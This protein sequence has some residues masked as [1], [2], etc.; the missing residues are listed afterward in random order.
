MDIIK[1]V[2]THADLNEFYYPPS[3]YTVVVRQEE[4]PKCGCVFQMDTSWITT[5]EYVE[6]KWLCPI[7]KQWSPMEPPYLAHQSLLDTLR[8]QLKGAVDTLNSNAHR[9]SR[10]WTTDGWTAYVLST[11]NPTQRK[12]DLRILEAI[13]TAERYDDPS[14]ENMLELA[15]MCCS[16][17]VF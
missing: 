7:C 17:H 1:K 14:P 4:C 15:A 16:V 10:K 12:F 9:G 3:E 8:A 11:S 13:A 6:G 2:Y 5:N